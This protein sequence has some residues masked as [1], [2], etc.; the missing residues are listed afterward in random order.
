MVFQGDDRVDLLLKV[1]IIPAFITPSDG[2]FCN[3]TLKEYELWR[4]SLV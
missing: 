4:A 1:P 2:N 3:Q